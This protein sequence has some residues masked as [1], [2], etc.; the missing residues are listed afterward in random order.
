M[1]QFVAGNAYAAGPARRIASNPGPPAAG[2]RGAGV[3][4]G[5][6]SLRRSGHST[7]VFST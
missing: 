5:A 7:Q 6:W 2:I 1:D 4:A 3:P